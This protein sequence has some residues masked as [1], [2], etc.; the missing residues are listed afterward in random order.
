[1]HGI[2]RLSHSTLI[3]VILLFNGLISFF[4]QAMITDV[5]V[6][7]LP[8]TQ[9]LRIRFIHAF[10]GKEDKFP[11]GQFVSSGEF[12]Y[13]GRQAKLYIYP[14][15]KVS[16][17]KS[18][19][20]ELHLKGEC[21]NTLTD[22]ISGLVF[23]HRSYLA[24]EKKCM[25]P[26]KEGTLVG[27]SSEFNPGFIIGVDQLIKTSEL[28]HDLGEDDF[29]IRALSTGDIQVHNKV[30]FIDVTW[31]ARK[32][33]IALAKRNGISLKSRPVTLKDKMPEINGESEPGDKMPAL[34][35][36]LYSESPIAN[37]SG[38]AFRIKQSEISDA[39]PHLPFSR[40]T[41][42]Y[43]GGGGESGRGCE[44]HQL[45][46]GRW[47]SN[48]ANKI[49]YHKS[50]TTRYEK[51]LKAW[52][53]TATVQFNLQLHKR[54]GLSSN[55]KTQPLIANLHRKILDLDAISF[56]ESTQPDK[57]GVVHLAMAGLGH[58][59][60]EGESISVA[61]LTSEAFY[62]G[63]NQYIVKIWPA[64]S[65][66]NPKQVMLAVSENQTEENQTLP[67]PSDTA[68]EPGGFIVMRHRITARHVLDSEDELPKPFYVAL[69]TGAAGS[70]SSEVTV[71]LMPKK[72][73][74]KTAGLE[75][76]TVRPVYP[77]KLT[78]T[79]RSAAASTEPFKPA[80]LAGHD[81][82]LEVS[83][84]DLAMCRYCRR[85]YQ[86]PLTK[87]EGSNSPDI[88]FTLIVI[89]FPEERCC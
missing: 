69:E 63:R 74:N 47:S 59:G 12:E 19:A 41:F 11:V 78:Y 36:E 27:G 86:S 70:E 25:V 23:E 79:Q 65:D 57:D 46:S 49:D 2:F 76:F 81:Y 84:Y 68:M 61:P 8:D 42:S 39:D 66:K 6:S 16:S 35:L 80:V 72:E 29:H 89:C 82:T 83:R 28:R 58:P 44:S 45:E 37:F 87:A 34:H 13:L 71:G 64:G 38:I 48:I 22:N 88:V 15:G 20:V 7:I 73:L 51:V 9:I 26:F 4:A 10:T 60:G 56:I 21:N 77:A 5:V 30:N 50:T 75:Q 43:L 52:P 18:V 31:T 32:Q 33:D 85:P 3:L 54:A 24:D 53:G 17:P 62:W 40:W 14:A 55:S 67:R 1:M